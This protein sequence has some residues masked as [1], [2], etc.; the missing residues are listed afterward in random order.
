MNLQAEDVELLLKAC[1][2][3]RSTIPPYLQVNQPE[4]EHLNGLI[5]K[6][7]SSTKEPPE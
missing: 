6:L 2:K 7:E 5:A 1:R 3:Y 4:L